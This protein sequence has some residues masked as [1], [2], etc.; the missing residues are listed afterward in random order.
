[1]SAGGT[2]VGD[3]TAVMAVARMS[4]SIAALLAVIAVAVAIAVVLLAIGGI[5]ALIIID[6]CARHDLPRSTALSGGIVR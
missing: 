6:P 2:V 4:V 1:V 3:T 5:L